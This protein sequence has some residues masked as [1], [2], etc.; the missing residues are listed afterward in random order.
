MNVWILESIQRL[1]D[2]FENTDWNNYK[3][4][5]YLHTFIE[6]VS[7]YIQFYQGICIPSMSVTKYPNSCPLCNK[8]IKAKDEAFQIKYR[9]F[10]RNKGDVLKAIRDTKKALKD[11]L[12][13]KFASNN[14]RHMVQH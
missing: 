2:C 5:N 3:D 10:H 9:T 12:E 8:T 7:A 11:P 1:H 14:S 6:T 13:K 4:E